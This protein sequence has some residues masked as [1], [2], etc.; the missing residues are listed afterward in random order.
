MIQTISDFKSR[1]MLAIKYTL[2]S[3]Q[4]LEIYIAKYSNIMIW[5]NLSSNKIQLL[6]KQQFVN[7]IVESFSIYTRQ[8]NF[9]VS[10][11][12]SKRDI[13]IPLCP[14]APIRKSLI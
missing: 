14:S 2:T 8:Q 1:Y 4:T 7:H 12:R 3:K 9:I 5:I 11:T 6:Q 13:K 10:A